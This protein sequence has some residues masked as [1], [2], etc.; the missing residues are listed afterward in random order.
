[1]AQVQLMGP[2]LELW[3]YSSSALIFCRASVVV[4]DSERSGGWTEG[5]SDAQ[6]LNESRAGGP[7]TL[8]VGSPVDIGAPVVPANFAPEDVQFTY[9]SEGVSLLGIVTY[10]AAPLNLVL[11][12][13]PDTGTAEITNQATVPIEFD[14]F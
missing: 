1:M 10:E 6:S 3:L 9:S 11:N 2:E 13:D 5:A 8:A 7:T 14:G 12:V 4:V